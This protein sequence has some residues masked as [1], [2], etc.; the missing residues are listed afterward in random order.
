MV[1]LCNPLPRVRANPTRTGMLSHR[2]EVG[3]RRALG[4][5]ETDMERINDVQQA[6][7]GFDDEV[8]ATN[9]NEV[10]VRGEVLL[11]VGSANQKRAG[12]CNCWRISSV[13][14]AALSGLRVRLV[15][16]GP[17]VLLVL[18][19]GLAFWRGSRPAARRSTN[20]S[21]SPSSTASVLLVS[22]PVRRSFTMR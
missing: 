2:V 4:R 8:R 6:I 15:K 17:L 10:R 11:A 12:P 3:R 20:G 7:F 19:A 5:M 9:K 14:M 13:F 1:S 16:S 22:Q 18:E 21:T